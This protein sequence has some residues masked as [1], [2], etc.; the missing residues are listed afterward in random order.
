V[1]ENWHE[2]VRVMALHAYGYCKRLC[3]LEE[4]E[5]VRIADDRVYAGRR[6]H[7]EIEK[8]DEEREAKTFELR[9]QTLGLSGKLDAVRRRDGCWIPYEHKRGRSKDGED[10]PAAWP[11]DQLQVGAYAMLL[12]EHTGIAIPEG[13]V[14]Y[15]A[16]GKLVHVPLSDGLRNEVKEAVQA[17][18]SMRQQQKRPP[19]CD[20]ERLCI[21]CSLAPECLPEETRRARDDS[22]DTVRLFPAKS[23][24]QTL[25]LT[26]P[27][28]TVGRTRSSLHLY[29]TDLDETVAA[30]TVEALVLHGYCQITTQALNLCH[31]KH[32]AVHWLSPA[33]HYLG[34]I[35][36][37]PRTIHKKLRQFRA[38]E[39]PAVRLRLARK[40]ARSKVSSQRRFLLRAT[41]DDSDARRR[42]E[43]AIETLKQA[44]EQ[45]A[46]APDADSLRGLEGNAARA[47]F[48]VFN[49]MIKEEFHHAFGFERRSRR[50]P[51][52]R[53]NSLLS[54]GYALLF[55]N[56]HAAIRVVGLEPALGVF[57]RPRSSAPPL[58]LDLMELF[59]V[60]LWDMPLVGSVNRGQ[61][62]PDDDF[63][64]S[65]NRV[66]LSREGRKKAIRIFETRLEDTWVHPVL[67]YSLSYRRHIELEARLMLKEIDQEANLFARTRIR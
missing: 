46:S 22:W 42:A 13:R 59:R 18:R 41:R 55:S 8:E 47:Y 63:N 39:Q 21:H 38:F 49:T 60:P 5:E 25:H 27:G 6:L 20:N 4:V 23:E 54:F 26:R 2:P 12:E 16:D 51:E 52:D 1:N 3:Y 62:D 35:C 44:G 66:W 24:R 64:I 58:V 14:R 67:D 28:T 57:H 37:T 45:A 40:I 29:G 36:P 43:T 11:S 7:T 9:S 50:P 30:N 61:W 53:I 15:H 31:R 48:S 65:P 32:I 33:G 56:V 19:V 34:G 17:I 10:G